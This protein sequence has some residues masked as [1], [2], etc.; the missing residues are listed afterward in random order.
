MAETTGTTLDILQNASH[1]VKML[2]CSTGSVFETVTA[3]L[4]TKDQTCLEDKERA[5]RVDLNFAMQRVFANL[6]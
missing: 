2:R 6:R 4:E 5:M 3:G 1:A